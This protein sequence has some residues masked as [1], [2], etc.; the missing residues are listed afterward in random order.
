[1]SVAQSVFNHF[2]F[3]SMPDVPPDSLVPAMRSAARSA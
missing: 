2:R 1:L 3:E